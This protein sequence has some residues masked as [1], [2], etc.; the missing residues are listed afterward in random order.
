MVSFIQFV[1]AILVIMLH[2]S[3]LFQNDAYHFI[4]KSIFSRMAVPFFIVCSSFLIRAKTSQ[5][6]GYQ[7]KYFKKYI[8]TYLIWS[9]IFI[10]YGLFYFASLSLTPTLIPLGLLVALFYTGICY[11]LWYIPAF[12]TGTYLVNSVLKKTKIKY[13]IFFFLF[14]FAIG[15][16]ETYSS[17]IKN[18]KLL[19][20]Y[21]GYASF[22]LTSRN[23]LFFTPIFVCVGYILYDYSERPI[24]TKYYFLKLCVAFLF[25]CLE[26]AIIFPNQGLD[27][28]FLFTLIPFSMFLFNWAIRTKLFKDKSFSKLKKLSTLY[29]FIHP[30]FIELISI[31]TIVVLFNA[32]YFGWIKFIFTLISTH[33]LSLI[34][35]TVLPLNKK[36]Q[37]IDTV[38]IP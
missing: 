10:P 5:G 37:K 20:L 23:G 1:F 2:S 16:I 27:K 9:A 21:T 32:T 30:I 22:F 31:P 14:L 17:F 8:K 28:N 35:L 38:K 13:V 12:L 29:F 34:I 3:R 33:L 11:H 19:S 4:Q 24:F 18:T 36:N 6:S 7:K 15:S 25:L 26:G